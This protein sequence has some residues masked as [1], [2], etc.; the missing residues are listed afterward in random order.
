MSIPALERRSPSDWGCWTR[1]RSDSIVIGCLLAAA[2][3]GEL[4]AVG[5]IT[6]TVPHRVGDTHDRSP[7]RRS[8]RDPRRLEI[9]LR[10]GDRMLAQ[11]E[12]RG[13]E[14]GV[15]AAPESTVHKV[16]EGSHPP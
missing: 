16:V 5:G 3:R 1:T 12:D 13:G 8:D 2:W 11:V 14:Q 7:L 4:F 9:G 6:G 10:F 15:R